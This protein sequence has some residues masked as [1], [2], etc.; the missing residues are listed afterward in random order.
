[1][2]FS[3][4]VTNGA[5]QQP[6]G[7]SAPYYRNVNISWFLADYLNTNEWTVNSRNG[8]DGI[9][10]MPNP[11]PATLLLFGSGLVGLGAWGRKKLLKKA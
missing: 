4:Q 7:W 1:M 2:T 11:E 3:T 10:P 5:P 6:P 9:A 8:N